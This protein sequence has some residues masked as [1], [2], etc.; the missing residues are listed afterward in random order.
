MGFDCDAAAGA[1]AASQSDRV[2]VGFDR[3]VEDESAGRDGDAASTGAAEVE[4]EFLRGAAAAAGAP[5]RGERFPRVDVASPCVDGFLTRRTAAAMAGARAVEARRHAGRGRG[6][7]QRGGRDERVLPDCDIRGLDGERAAADRRA[8]REDEILRHEDDDL[9]SWRRARK[10]N[11]VA[12]LERSCTDYERAHAQRDGRP[13]PTNSRERPL[14]SQIRLATQRLIRK[15]RPTLGL[16]TRLRRHTSSRLR[17][18]R[19]TDPRGKPI[20][21]A[22][23]ISLHRLKNE[24]MI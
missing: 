20:T 14:A 3:A 1:A 18:T 7:A 23:T 5:R 4:V 19:I 15:F 10:R 21:I 16:V 8:G 6:A 17:P 11:V 9:T 12:D 22:I 13:Q 2:A 24:A